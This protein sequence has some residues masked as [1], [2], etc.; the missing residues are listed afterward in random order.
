M[1]K[2]K[3]KI[4]EE[5]NAS[6]DLHSNYKTSTE[7]PQVTQALETWFTQAEHLGMV[8]NGKSLEK[9]NQMISSEAYLINEL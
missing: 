2:D 8:L 6:L 3:D 1:V 4:Q 7:H 9:F 5:Y